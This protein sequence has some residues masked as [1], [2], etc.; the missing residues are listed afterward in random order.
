MKQGKALGWVSVAMI[1]MGGAAIGGLG[2]DAFPYEEDEIFWA[3]AAV[4]LAGCI[5]L[6][7]AMLAL[8]RRG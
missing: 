3:G 1:A 2:T 8:G 5:G 4:A 6:I 7:A